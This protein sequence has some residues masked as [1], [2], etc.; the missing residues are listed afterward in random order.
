MKY[1]IVLLTPN[2]DIAD[3]CSY[4]NEESFESHYQYF[5]EHSYYIIKT[6]KEVR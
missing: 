3:I 4:D 6:F 2:Y 1:Y 5:N